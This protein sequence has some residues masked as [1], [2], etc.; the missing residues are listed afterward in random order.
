MF[1]LSIACEA[2]GGVLVNATPI[3]DYPSHRDEQWLSLSLRRELTTC[4]LMTPKS[5][6]EDPPFAKH[7][8]PELLNFGGRDG[9]RTHD[10]LIANEESLKLRRVVTIS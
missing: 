6:M 7:E 1:S 8:R 3:K 9:I 5:R 10:L 4:G 2:Y